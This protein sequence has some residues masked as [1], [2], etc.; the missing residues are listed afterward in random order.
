MQASRKLGATGLPSPTRRS[1]SAS[2]SRTN[3]RCAALPRLSSSSVSSTG[4]VP[5][6]RPCLRSSSMLASECPVCSS[7]I[8]SSNR[9]D[10]GTFSSSVDIA[11]IGARVFGS[12]SK[13]SLA[14]KRTARMM[15]TGSSR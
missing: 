2:A 5:R 9:R 1:V 11:W 3:S 15:R 14:A 10:G 4:K 12:I 7:L 8:I 13:P 6:C